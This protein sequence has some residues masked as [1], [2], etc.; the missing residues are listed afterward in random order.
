M[1]LT[2]MNPGCAI[3]DGHAERKALGLKDTEVTPGAK[4]TDMQAVN[5]WKPAPPNGAKS[6]VATPAPTDT[7][8]WKPTAPKKV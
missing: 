3:T 2:E 1:T 7:K 6:P 8:G 5:G 4:P